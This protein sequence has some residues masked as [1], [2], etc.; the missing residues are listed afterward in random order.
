MYAD[1]AGLRLIADTL[2]AGGIPST[3]PYDRRRN[4]H[5][6]PRGWAHTAVRAILANPIYGGRKVWGTQQRHEELLD[7]TDVAAG[8][9]TRMR[10]R[11]DSQ[12]I[13]AETN[14]TPALV[15]PELAARVA[16]RFGQ[17][18][19][20]TKARDTK[21]AYLLRGLLYCG[22]CGR[23][24]QGSARRPRT[25]GLPA[26]VLYRCEVGSHRSSPPGSI[27]CQRCTYG[28]TPSC[29]SSTPGWPR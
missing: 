3:A 18:P 2:T 14:P 6:D 1:G 23:M 24:L 7:V 28:R 9:I 25:T 4:P 27:T 20:R 5:R 17:G 21:H 16:A 10:W 15:G 29:R 26:R 19:A 22:L 8:H 12:W 13:A 11:P